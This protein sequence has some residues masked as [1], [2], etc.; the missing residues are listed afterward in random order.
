MKKIINSVI[1]SMTF[2]FN[3]EKYLT[4]SLHRDAHG[5]KYYLITA[6]KAGMLLDKLEHPVLP[7][8]KYRSVDVMARK[9]DTRT[10]DAPK[11]PIQIDM[12]KNKIVK[13]NARLHALAKTH[14]PAVVWIELV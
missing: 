5:C 7:S 9:S 13:G 12:K 10:F 11:R 8:S 6:E 4:P 2:K 14:K 1:K 3:V